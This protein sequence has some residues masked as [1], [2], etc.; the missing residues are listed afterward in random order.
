M[1]P[2]GEMPKLSELGDW[3]LVDKDQ[4]LRGRP[5]LD[6]SGDRLGVVRRMLVDRDNRRVAAVVLDDGRTIAIEDVE[7]RD[8]EAWLDREPATMTMPAGE[9]GTADDEVAIPIAEEQLVVGKRTV[10]RGQIHVRTHT[11]ETPVHEEVRLR[12]EHVDVERRPVNERVSDTTG[13]FKDRTVEMTETD[14]EAVIGKEARVVEEVVVRK[15]EGERRERIDD[16][17]RRTEVDVERL[18]D[19]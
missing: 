16:T 6:P 3:Q 1:T 19:R 5:L 14:E 4:D 13:L 12:D 11:V 2:S 17:V 7:I 15:Q 9:R 18:D 10:A 8:G